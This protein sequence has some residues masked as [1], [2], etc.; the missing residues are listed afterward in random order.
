MKTI[1]SLKGVICWILV[2]ALVLS[3]N[4]ESINT[5]FAA[6]VDSQKELTDTTEPIEEQEASPL[7]TSGSS[8]K[9][10]DQ[11]EI[12]DCISKD[13]NLHKQ[14]IKKLDQYDDEHTIVYKNKDGSNTAYIFTDPIRYTDENGKLKYKDNNIIE[15][16][17][18]E[19]VHT[20]YKY[21]NKANEFDVYLP[22]DL[23]SGKGPKLEYEDKYS[24]EYTFES[25][26]SNGHKSKEKKNKDDSK[27]RAI[28]YAASFDDDIT[29]NFSTTNNG[30]KDEIII[31]KY[32]GQNNFVF[33]L[34]LKGLTPEKQD[35]GFINLKDNKT[36]EVIA[37]IEPP[38]A[39]DSYT[40]EY[41]E[42]EGH[43]TEN[44]DM[45]IEPVKGN[46]KYKLTITVDED[47]LKDERTVYP[48]IIDPVTSLTLN[49]SKMG[50]TYICRECRNTHTT[51]PFI[52][53]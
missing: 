53:G 49:Y 45:L 29:I 9:S 52:T 21:K 26:L 12:P 19:K 50:D 46:K 17:G 6:E 2:V 23:F 24:I 13:D 47:F 44:I 37:K 41:V 3:A 18:A 4:I 31:N 36:S 35:S 40:G 15:L 30:I 39:V 20:G 42:G 32:T 51:V 48:V 11:L 34:D 7:P 25:Q 16:T 28:E 14:H 8:I 43:F 1:K 10:K 33:Y 27:I 22:G 5:A 38:F